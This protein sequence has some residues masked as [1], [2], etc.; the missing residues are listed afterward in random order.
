MAALRL[1]DGADWKQSAWADVPQEPHPVRGGS[2]QVSPSGSFSLFDTIVFK[3]V[4]C[5]AVS[6]IGDD[7]ISTLIHIYNTAARTFPY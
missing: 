2:S 1:E 7:L 6:A 3:F 5:A 4:V